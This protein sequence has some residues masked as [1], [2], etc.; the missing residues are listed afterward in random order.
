MAVVKFSIKDLENFIGRKLTKWD[1]EENIPMIGAPLEKIENDSVYYEITPNRPDFLSAEGFARGIKTFLG[2]SRGL[3]NFKVS[4]P[5]NK[6]LV[7]SSVKEVRPYVVCSLVKNV[8]M[9]DELVTSLVQLQEKLIETHG[10]KRKK[11]AIGLHDFDKVKTPFSYKAVKP[12]EIKFIPLEM[13]EK[14]SL[15]EIVKKHPKGIEY[16]N[17]IKDYEKWP[18]IVDENNDVLSFPPII[19]SELTRVTE[20]TKNLFIEITGISELAVEQALN[21]IVTSLYERGC[22]IESF[23][24]VDEKKKI[25]PDLKPRK[26]KVNLDYINKILGLKLN[27][28]QFIKMVERMGFGFDGKIIIPPYRTDVMHAIDIAEDVAISYGYRNFEPVLLKTKTLT[29]MPKEEKVSR[30]REIM[31]S[32]GFQEV[33]NMI[34][35]NKENEF[36]KMRVKEEMTYETMNPVSK[37]CTIC[38]KNILPSL[39]KVLAQNKHHDFPQRIFELGDVLEL[40]KR[41]ETKVKNYKK[42]GCVISNS[43]VSF[44]EI[45][46]VLNYLLD[47]L[48]IQFKLK[49]TKH[50]SFIRGRVAEVLARNKMIG[51]IGEVSPEVLENWDLF[52]PVA[53]FEIDLAKLEKN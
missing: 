27:K 13:K 9:T 38:R 20:K 32:A 16:A 10:R 33:V 4:P 19:N 28:N 43:K 2:I 18:V 46:P 41:A 3:Q 17:I 37:E 31:V 47:E 23:Q 36:L 29:D 7:E 8:K 11:V 12:D 49:S 39:L 26:I 6:M 30:I 50:P 22:E 51:I 48:K 34:L 44:D 14:M 53:A 24:I 1:L 40:D 45:Y 35:T 42:L 52:M 21:I 5:R 15:E 25:T